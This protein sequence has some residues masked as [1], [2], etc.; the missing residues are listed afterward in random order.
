MKGQKKALAL[1]DPSQVGYDQSQ[2]GF[3]SIKYFN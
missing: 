1:K 2:G 3:N